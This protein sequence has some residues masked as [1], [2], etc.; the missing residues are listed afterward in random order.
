MTSRKR[1]ASVFV[2]SGL[3]LVG[4]GLW[5]ADLMR[6][7]AKHE[8]HVGDPADYGPLSSSQYAAAVA[9]AQHEVDQEGAHLTS[10]TAA[11]RPGQ[12]HQPNLPGS[13]TSGRVILIRLV[14]RFPHVH[15]NQT[16]GQPHRGGTTV[17]ITADATT[18]RACLLVV[19]NAHSHAYRRSAD[20]LPALSP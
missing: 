2:V 17:G 12:V 15:G 20:L 10:A 7:D 1:T 3:L 19:R 18:G 5:G 6:A 11:L 13:C 14:G 4:V 16:A 9:V 8:S